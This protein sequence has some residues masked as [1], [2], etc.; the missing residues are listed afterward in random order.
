LLAP[1]ARGVDAGIDMP[2]RLIACAQR[3]AHLL[4]FATLSACPSAPALPALPSVDTASYAPAVR[5]QIEAAQA[6]AAAEPR[7]PQASGELGMILHA[8]GLFDAA[9][10]CYERARQLAPNELRWAYYDALVLAQRGRSSDAIAALERAAVLK[11]GV[12]DVQLELARQLRSAGRV[13]DANARLSALA[14]EYADDPQ[15]QLELGRTL[16]DLD[17]AGAAAERFEHALEL[18][19]DRGDVHY[20][21]ALAYQRLGDAA[22]AATHFAAHEQFEDRPLVG[23]TALPA[24]VARYDLGLQQAV[25]DARG[26][27]LVLSGDYAGALALVDDDAK[28]APWADYALA[29][30]FEHMGQPLAALPLLQRARN[31]ADQAGD[32]ELVTAIDSELRRGLSEIAPR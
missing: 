2:H 29:L 23:V 12:R 32:R 22:R 5:A 31:G 1:P 15:V 21:L 25:R 4:V 13:Q 24:E 6:R 30:R 10:R 18:A 9:A 11:P 16:L 28:S 3:A 19:G 7:D 26:R 27:A 17:Q 20:A 14:T 8:Y